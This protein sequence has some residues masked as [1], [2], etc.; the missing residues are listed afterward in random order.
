[1]DLTQERYFL[2]LTLDLVKSFSVFPLYFSWYPW[3]P[4]I[5]SSHFLSLWLWVIEDVA[6]FSRLISCCAGFQGRWNWALGELYVK[7]LLC[8][9]EMLP[10]YPCLLLMLLSEICNIPSASSMKEQR[11]LAVSLGCLTKRSM[12]KIWPVLPED[13]SYSVAQ[14]F[15]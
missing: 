11:S 1:M 6:C 2:R 12:R 14:E 3:S 13:L 7:S 8:F 10:E 9:V 15:L 5:E 4:H